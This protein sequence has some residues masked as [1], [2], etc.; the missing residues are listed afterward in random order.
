MT[1]MPDPSDALTPLEERMLAF[2]RSW[3]SRDA[4]RE[5]AIRD[6]FGLSP[7]DFHRQLGE[8]IGRP[9]AL[10]FDPLL[11]RRLRRL[12]TSRQRARSERRSEPRS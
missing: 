9:A 5:T 2:E 12:R 8:L 1:A 7:A 3:W 6:E 10:D 4:D 11:V